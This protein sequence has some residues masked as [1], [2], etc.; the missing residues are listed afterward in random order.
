MDMVG[1][2]G[3][4]S[5]EEV[6]K[7]ENVSYKTDKKGI[8]YV[9]K[10]VSAWISCDVVK[11]VDAGS[12]YVIIGRVTDGEILSDEKVMTYSGYKENK[13]KRTG[14]KCTVCGYV[15]EGES[16]PED[17]I[18]PICKHGASDFEKL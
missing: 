1:E 8:P 16:L 4:K 17:Y 15:Y 6:N 7:F 10:D 14:W 9:T 12:H 2:F 5:S 18:C 11:T 13:N 3:F